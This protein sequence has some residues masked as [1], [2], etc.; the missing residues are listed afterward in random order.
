MQKIWRNPLILSGDI[1]DQRIL[2]SDIAQVPFGEITWV[3]AYETNET[4][5]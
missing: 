1:N 3:F 5:W 2:Q 4:L